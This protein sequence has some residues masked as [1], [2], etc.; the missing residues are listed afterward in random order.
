MSWRLKRSVALSV[1]AD[2]VQAIIS[3]PRLRNTVW[4]TESLKEH[5]DK[6]GLDYTLEE[7]AVLNDEMHTRGIVEDI[8]EA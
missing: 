7:V 4:T 2:L 5:L 8:P 6:L 1:S 3:M